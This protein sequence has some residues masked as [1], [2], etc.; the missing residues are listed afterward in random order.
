MW[1]MH[2]VYAQMEW[3]ETECI[4]VERILVFQTRV[5]P[6]LLARWS[7]SQFILRTQIQK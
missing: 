1:D 5:I 7:I 6:E 3:S 2:V 4:A